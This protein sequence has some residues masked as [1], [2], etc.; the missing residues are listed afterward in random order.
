MCVSE[1]AREWEWGVGTSEWMS[2]AWA[3]EW[4]NEWALCADL[5]LIQGWSPNNTI[6]VTVSTPCWQDVWALL[7]HVLLW[8]HGLPSSWEVSFWEICSCLFHAKNTFS[9]QWCLHSYTR[10]G[11]SYCWCCIS[12]TPWMLCLSIC[13][14]GCGVSSRSPSLP[15]KWVFQKISFV[16]TNSYENTRIA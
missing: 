10:R 9:R 13:L 8:C 2:G 6:T 1:W 4:M 7:L 5:I 14:Q 15:H 12:T 11:A 3:W 16:E